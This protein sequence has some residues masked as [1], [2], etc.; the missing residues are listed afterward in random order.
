MPLNL[1]EEICLS[2]DTPYATELCIIEDDAMSVELQEIFDLF[3]RNYQKQEFLIHKDCFHP[4]F[5][6][7][8][9]CPDTIS[10]EMT[11]VIEECLKC[12]E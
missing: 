6:L 8:Y 3:D 5:D 1:V 4:D 7:W 9:A 11:Y 12:L 2:A 10:I